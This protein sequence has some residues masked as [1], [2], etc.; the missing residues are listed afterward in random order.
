MKWNLIFVGLLMLS[1]SS[2]NNR[3]NYMDQLVEIDS[4]LVLQSDSAYNLLSGIDSDKLSPRN[5]IY[6]NLLYVIAADKSYVDF[7]SDSLISTTTNSSVF[8]K[9]PYNRFR[10]NLY[11]GLIRLRLNE[12]DSLGYYRLLKA[13]EI[14]D[15]NIISDEH[16]KRLLFWYIGEYNKKYS[17][18]EIAENYMLKEKELIKRN[19]WEEYRYSNDINLFWVYRGQGKAEE[20]K[21]IID[22][23]EDER[24]I[25]NIYMLNI[26]NIKTAYYYFIKDYEK[27]IE[28][29]KQEA[30]ERQKNNQRVKVYYSIA[31]SYY[32]LKQLDSAIK[33]IH[34]AKENNLSGVD[35]DDSQLLFYYSKLLGKYYFEKGDLNNSH[36]YYEES[37]TYHNDLIKIHSNNS[38]ANVE[39]QL[40]I[41]K[42]DRAI[43]QIE[44]SRKLTTSTGVLLVFIAILIMM[45]L[46]NRSRINKK[47]AE[48]NKQK[49][50]LTNQ[51]L[52]ESEIV[53]SFINITIGQFDELS[54]YM[55]QYV[56]NKNKD[57]VEAMNALDRK[58]KKTRSEN[59]KIFLSLIESEVVISYFPLMSKLTE[60]TLFEK[61]IILMLKLDSP[62]DSIIKIYNS[63]YHS[64]R[65]TK[66]NMI[67]KIETS[68][69]LAEDEK[70]YLI[71]L[72]KKD[73][74]MI[75][76][77]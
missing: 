17:N 70:N 46:H 16:Y 42:R 34:L 67:P 4:I 40:E 68:T 2:C 14:C 59:R 5:R 65:S 76:S 7:E 39:K 36:R 28:Y 74:K 10:A 9:D 72:I 43:E 73:A 37:L 48:L 18:Y 77:H 54:D 35:R 53:N 49:A 56:S 21:N 11:H 75:N 25:P 19:N 15:K 12:Y 66:N 60:F 45:L 50:E 58:T 31:D 38:A 69:I 55:Y 23:Y 32:Q 51:K 47:E 41:E 30:I 1:L 20:M 26:Y 52:V 63:T 6:Y 29:G 57:I 62:Q 27:T 64:I 61:I 44:A 33:Y 3:G 71:A 13:E 22:E 8:R 24:D